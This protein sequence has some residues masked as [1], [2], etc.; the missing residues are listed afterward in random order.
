MFTGI[1]EAV[2]Q[3]AAVEETK[4]GRRLVVAA[5]WCD[6]LALGES[7]SVDGACLTVDSVDAG[8]FSAI[9][10]SATLARTIA[11]HYEPGAPVNLERAARMGDRL[12]GHLVQGH[13]DGVADL[14]SVREAGA[15][16]LLAFE[17]PEEVFEVTVPLGSIALNGASLTVSG[18]DRNR[19]CEVA[20]IPHT[21][22]HTNLRHLSAGASVNA[23]SDLIGKYV[24]RFVARG[25]AA[26]GRRSPPAT[27]VS[28]RDPSV[29]ES[30]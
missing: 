28:V 23:E 29:G 25:S 22:E 27:G 15:T 8:A 30:V 3:V 20:V 11:A 14:A 19:V 18:L 24:R 26:S 1:V 2:G 13:V 6:E 17:L 16:R 4:G 9:A 10:G 21:W 12:G 7:V 5:P